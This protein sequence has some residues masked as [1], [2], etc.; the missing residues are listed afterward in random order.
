MMMPIPA[1][2]AAAEHVVCELGS[3]ASR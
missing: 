2:D 1:T 3:E